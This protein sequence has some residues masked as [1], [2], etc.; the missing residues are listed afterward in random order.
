[1]MYVCMAIFGLSHRGCKWILV[2]TAYIIQ[3]AAFYASSGPLSPLLEGI[4]ADFPENPAKIRDQF[5]LD[6]KHTVLAVCPNPSCRQT[7][8]PV[9]IDDI[10][11]YRQR[12]NNEIYSR[13]NRKK[14]C[15][16]ELVRP[17]VVGG[18]TVAVPILPFISFDFKDWVAWLTSR[19]QL[20][21]K[22]DKAWES[23]AD[24]PPV[25]LTDLFHGSVA[26]ELRGADGKLFGD[27]GE[28]GRY[29][30]S[31]S[32]D[33]FNPLGN[34]QAGKKISVGVI[35]VVC[36]NIP[37][38]QRY[39]P[40]NMFLAGIIPGPREPPVDACNHFLTPL[41]DDLLDFWDPGVFFSATSK[42]PNGRRVRCALIALVC[43]LPAA[44]KIAGFAGHSANHFCSRCKC[45]ENNET[46][47]NFDIKS[48]NFRE[49]TECRKEG[50]Q[51]KAAP[52]ATR[53][54]EIFKWYGR[55]WSELERLPYFDITRFVVVDPMHNLLLGLLQEHFRFVLGFQPKHRQQKQAY[56]R[57]IPPPVI[58]LPITRQPL[59]RTKGGMEC[60]TRV[61]GWL[62]G[63]M[64]ALLNDTKSV[65]YDDTFNRFQN[66]NKDALVEVAVGLGIPTN[67]RM[68]RKD[69]VE[70]IFQ[71]VCA[72]E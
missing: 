1:M 57:Y 7:Y 54:T 46:L 9:I 65:E 67:P 6:G 25:N 38:E 34:R 5:S 27:G 16:T 13:G 20:E 61:V 14:K 41:V 30:F 29:L 55:R 22:M 17:K 60:Y 31:L 23:L 15:R 66:N 59:F 51:F 33:W 24:E 10:P 26:R 69:L 37:P 62:R 48:W 8:R 53:A 21:H 64:T 40:E 32:V 52:T 19:P 58:D 49:N 4:L 43:D 11:S 70:A 71:W 39:K 56:E 28:E 44:R 12:C 2:M 63:P 18:K 68:Q 45:T 72:R 42:Y 50:E 47:N 35:S 3:T 36:L